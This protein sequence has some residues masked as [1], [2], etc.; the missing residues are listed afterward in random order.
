MTIAFDCITEVRLID[1]KFYYGSYYIPSHGPW[2][3]HEIEIG[4]TPGQWGFPMR[5]FQSYEPALYLGINVES[6]FTKDGEASC[7]SWW[8]RGDKGTLRLESLI[9][10]TFN[11]HPAMV[12]FK[13]DGKPVFALGNKN[14]PGLFPLLDDP[15]RVPGAF[16]LV[17]LKSGIVWV[18][19]DGA[20]RPSRTLNLNRL[21]DAFVGGVHPFP[22]VILGIQPLPNGHLLVAKRSESATNESYKHFDIEPQASDAHADERGEKEQRGAL[23]LFPE[24]EWVEVDPLPGE[25][26]KAEL[27]LVGNAPGFLKSKQ[28]ADRFSFG[29][30]PD[31]KLVC[32]WVAPKPERPEPERTGN[33]PSAASAKQP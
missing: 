16:V 15:I 12:P 13:K 6:G 2:E 20:T 9:E 28:D 3:D 32:P 24:I 7:C 29:F 14:L 4:A 17:S 25:V 19:K 8:K 21:G 11:G 30:D 10:V 1:K 23:I 27:D 33:A 22:N 31:G 5:L 26:M 18:I